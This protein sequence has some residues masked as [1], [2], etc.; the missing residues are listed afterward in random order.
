MS[1]GREVLQEKIEGL[2]PGK[3]EPSKEEHRCPVHKVRTKTALDVLDTTGSWNGRVNDLV[4]S[5]QVQERAE[6]T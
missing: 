1:N 3:E 4:Y 6:T 5:S 2:L